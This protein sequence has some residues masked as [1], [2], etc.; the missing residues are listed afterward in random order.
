MM[1]TIL[2]TVRLV[3]VAAALPHNHPE[4]EHWCNMLHQPQPPDPGSQGFASESAPLLL[5][6]CTRAIDAMLDLRNAQAKH[7]QLVLRGR[8]LAGRVELEKR[9]FPVAMRSYSLRAA[10]VSQANEGGLVATTVDVHL[11]N[12]SPFQLAL[13]IRCRLASA[14][15]SRGCV[16]PR[17][18]APAQA[19]L[20]TSLLCMPR[21]CGGRTL[22]AF[23][24]GK[25]ER[26]E[27]TG[28]SGNRCMA[29]RGPSLCLART[30]HADV[31][32]ATSSACAPPFAGRC[33]VWSPRAPWSARASL[34]RVLS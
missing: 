29:D 26:C 25:R 27:D 6:G 20:T 10:C 30:P 23:A 32:S 34:P 3:L 33:P 2:A 8:G 19:E 14:P 12:A 21:A 24:V 31:C 9:R 5:E 15:R 1:R 11:G 4:G 18:L 16:S 7:R 22:R 13:S 28:C 17:F